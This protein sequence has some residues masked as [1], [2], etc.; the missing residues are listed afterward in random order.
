MTAVDEKATPTGIDEN[1]DTGD[2]EIE[3]Y[4]TLAPVIALNIDTEEAAAPG[5]GAGYARYGSRYLKAVE[6]FVT[7]NNVP[8]LDVC[9]PTDLM[10]TDEHFQVT[11]F[12][13]LTFAAGSETDLL[14]RQY[15][16]VQDKA[17]DQ[18]ERDN[19]ERIFNGHLAE[20][21]AEI[22]RKCSHHFRIVAEYRW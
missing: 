14:L 5:A 22:T 10:A 4:L 9:G 8:N 1:T 7:A 16:E 12:V 18:F 21:I 13:T 3:V 20:Y 11:T 19:A 6:G 17:T 15:Q 2:K